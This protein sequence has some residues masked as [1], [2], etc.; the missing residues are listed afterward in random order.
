MDKEYLLYVLRLSLEYYRDSINKMKIDP[1]K[2]GP[3]GARTPFFPVYHRKN[4]SWI[5]DSLGK[6]GFDTSQFERELSEI[7]EEFRAYGESHKEDILNSLYND[8][9]GLIGSY[10][11]YFSDFQ[12]YKEYFRTK[13][14]VDPLLKEYFLNRDIGL[15]FLDGYE[16]DILISI[17]TYI[18]VLFEYLDGKFDLEELKNKVQKMDDIFKKDLKD[19]LKSMGF[20]K[21]PSDAQFPPAKYWWRHLN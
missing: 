11:E 1:G 20:D 7:D 5:L 2:M 19:I 18:E 13:E 10:E 14:D 9:K 4:I 12:K 15:Y 8:L 21:Y 6:I 16:F 17:R 3:H